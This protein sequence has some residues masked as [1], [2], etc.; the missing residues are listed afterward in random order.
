MNVARAL[1]QEGETE[2]ARPYLEKALALSPKLAR[3]EFFLALVQKAA[4]DYDARSASLADVRRQYPRDRVVVNQYGRMLFLQR[5]YPEAVRAF[6]QTLTSIPK[7]S[8]RI[9]T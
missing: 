2:A 4:G 5:R 6:Q 7:T 8:R 1:I 9:T 3:A